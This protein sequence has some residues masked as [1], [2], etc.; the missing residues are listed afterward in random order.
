[1]TYYK[2]VFK[3]GYSTIIESSERVNFKE[4]TNGSS[5]VFGNNYV[6]N[7]SDVIIIEEIKPLLKVKKPVV[8]D[9]K[10]CRYEGLTYCIDCFNNDLF[11]AKD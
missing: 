4:I 9:C 6:N 3:N 5:L 1:M 2:I 8:E 11:S 10:H 7:V